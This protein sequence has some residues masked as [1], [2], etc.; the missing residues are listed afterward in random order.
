MWFSMIKKKW[1]C[2]C[3]HSLHCCST[4]SGHRL[5]VSGINQDVCSWRK[6][7]NQI[8]IIT[9]TNCPSLCHIF[10]TLNAKNINTHYFIIRLYSCWVKII[11][12]ESTRA[13]NNASMIVVFDCWCL[14][15]KE[16]AQAARL[17]QVSY[18]SLSL[19]DSSQVASKIQTSC[20]LN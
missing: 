20:F 7:S 4:Y 9:P 8:Q 10:V 12:Y 17:S 14:M 18:K 16:A 2:Q 13:T 6:Q 15:M 19:P 5:T 1:E 3:E 11:H